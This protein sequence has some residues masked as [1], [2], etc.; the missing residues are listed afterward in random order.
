MKIAISVGHIGKLSKIDYGAVSGKG[1]NKESEIAL[2]YSEYLFSM[3]RNSKIQT[4]L[5]CHGFYASRLAYADNMKLD[6][7]LH[8]H[9]NA[10]GGRYSLCGYS[11]RAGKTTIELSKKI[12]NNMAHVLCTPGQVK[13]LGFLDRGYNLMEPTDAMSILLEPFFIDDPAMM[14][15][16]ETTT[17]VDQLCFEVARSVFEVLHLHCNK[18]N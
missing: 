18:F 16:M 7:I 13:K 14:K 15:K 8:S 5:M 6:L 1:R 9:V 3:L 11:E 17:G 2:K 10:G 12:S 4:Y